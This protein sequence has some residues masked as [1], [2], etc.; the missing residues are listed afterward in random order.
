MKAA[1]RNGYMSVLNGTW[2]IVP[3]ENHKMKSAVRHE[4]VSIRYAL[5]TTTARL[6]RAYESEKQRT[7]ANKT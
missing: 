4:R 3:A 7:A 1:F 6:G 5:A 2:V